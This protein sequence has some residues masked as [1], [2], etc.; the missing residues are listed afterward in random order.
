MEI[1]RTR[2]MHARLRPKRNAFRYTLSYVALPLSAWSAQGGASVLRFDPFGALRVEARDYGDGVTPP[3]AW[4]AAVLAREN[5]C[6]ADGA[7]TLVTLPRLLGY[8][9]NPVSF[10]LCRDR[11]GALRAVVAEV[12]NTFGER[13]AYLCCHDDHRSIAPGDRMPVRKIFHVSPFLETEGRYVFRFACEN[14]RLGIRI[15]LEDRDGVILVTAM[16]GRFAPLNT[17]GVAATLLLHPLQALKVVALIHWQALKL[18]LKGVPHWQKPQPP[19]EF[20]SR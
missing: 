15:N 7:V 2:I 17:A 3:G 11:G 1:V 9:F 12:N 6:E 19:Q 14:G 18:A 13:H 5:L 16:E 20:L 4:I 8:V 10:W